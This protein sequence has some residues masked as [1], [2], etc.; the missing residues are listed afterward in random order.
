MD[1]MMMMM[2]MNDE[3]TFFINTSSQKLLF[4]DRMNTANEETEILSDILG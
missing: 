4:N 2:V 3:P 1:V